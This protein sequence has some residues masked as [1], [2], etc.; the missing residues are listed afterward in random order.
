[1]PPLAGA[2]THTHAPGIIQPASPAFCTP[3]LLEQKVTS[4]FGAFLDPVA[5]KLMVRWVLLFGGCQ[6]GSTWH[7]RLKTAVWYGSALLLLS[8]IGRVLCAAC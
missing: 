2:G 7:K 5:D 3:P 6:V 8:S 4:A 1:M